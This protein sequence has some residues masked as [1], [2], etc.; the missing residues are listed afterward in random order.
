VLGNSESDSLPHQR[1]VVIPTP[2]RLVV[3]VAKQ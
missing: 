3:R 2:K 1:S